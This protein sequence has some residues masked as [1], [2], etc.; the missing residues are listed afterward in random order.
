MTAPDKSVPIMLDPRKRGAAV[1]RHACIGHLKIGAREVFT[2]E[3]SCG[4][5]CVREVSMTRDRPDALLCL[6]S[7][8]EHFLVLVNDHFDQLIAGRTEVFS[9]VEL[10]RFF[11]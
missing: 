9:R 4:Y 10:G 5:F 11:R 8:T 1:A 6:P 3:S 7:G 2:L